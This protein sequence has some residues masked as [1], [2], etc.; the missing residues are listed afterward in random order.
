MKKISALIMLLLSAALLAMPMYAAEGDALVDLYPY[1]DPNALYGPKTIH[2]L[3]GD[4]NWDMVFDGYRYHVVRGGVRYASKFNN[5]NADEYISA[6]ELGGSLSWNAFASVIIND[7]EEQFV[8]STTNIRTDLTSVVHRIYSYYDTEGKLVMVEDHVHN[9]NIVNDGTVAEPDYRF[10]TAEEIAASTE[11][12]PTYIA[13]PVRIKASE[14]DPK[15]FVMEPIKYLTWYNPDI[16]T[17][18]EDAASIIVS[19]NP[20]YVTIPSGWTIVSFG[21]NDRG[22][23]NQKTTDLVK[24]LVSKVADGF[25]GKMEMQY[26]AAAPAFSGLTPMDNDASEE[27]IQHVIELNKKNFQLPSNI[28]VTWVNM[29]DEDGNIQ[30][31]TEKIDYTLEIFEGETLVQTIEYTYDVETDTYVASEALM[32]F[33][34]KV[35]D[36]RYLAKYTATHPDGVTTVV[37]VN[38]IVGVLPPKFLNVQNRIHNEDVAIDLLGSIKAD[39][40]YGQDITSSIK[41]SHP[42]SLNTYYP[43]PGTYKID[44]TF[45]YTVFIPGVPPAH[46]GEIKVGETVYQV[47]TQDQIVPAGEYTGNKVHIW[48]SKTNLKFNHSGYANLVVAHFDEEG[49][50]IGFVDRLNWNAVGTTAASKVDSDA[51][52]K[53]WAESINFENG[54]YVLSVGLPALRDHI[55]TLAAGAELDINV[56]KGTLD[57]TTVLTKNTSYTLTVDDRTAPIALVVNDKYTVSS[58]DFS[59]V[60]D[61]ILANVVAFDE[62]DKN[63]SVYVASNGGMSLTKAGEYNV[64]VEAVDANGNS[65]VVAFKVKVVLP[66]A[67]LT[68]DDLDAAIEDLQKEIE[69]LQGQLLT[70]DKVL[71]LIQARLDEFEVP[72][73]DA[74]KVG[75]GATVG[76]SVGSALASFGGAFLLFRR[77]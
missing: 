23:Q 64:S 61:A 12:N 73:S 3:V 22:T 47:N 67:S 13:S 38:L 43:Q 30:D 5:A 60:N 27:G 10:A 63:L 68:Q 1:D 42:A 18:E 28:S 66:K 9:Y 20:N 69:D 49:K 26:I 54:G 8:L 44:L 29:F 48:S 17:G 7:T 53:A 14:T 74:G 45:D 31:K 2:T 58:E 55:R 40:G 24:T 37:D 16:S 77:R 59:N 25:E 71:E 34:T 70:E 72:Q 15:G 41:I 51:K 19:G 56:D 52:L 65:T 62:F 76:I 75:V 11:E 32:E 50:L 6:T 57:F 4:S 35:F 21:T 33:D 36:K 46:V 39:N